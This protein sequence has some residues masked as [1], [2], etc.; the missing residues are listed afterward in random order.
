MNKERQEFLDSL[1]SKHGIGIVRIH[2]IQRDRIYDDVVKL[3]S[4]NNGV[5]TLEYP[6]HVQFHNE[7][8]VDVGGVTRDMF[9]AF[10]DEVYV[11]LFD[12]ST[13]LHPAIH[14][15]VDL[16]TFRVIGRVFS[17]AYLIAGM[18]PDRIAFPCLAA[19]FLGQSVSIP[20]IVL[21]ESFLFS[22]CTYDA[23]V[24]NKALKLGD[25]IYPQDI[26]EGLNTIFSNKGC[27]ELPCAKNLTRLISQA[28]YYTFLIKPAAALNMLN[29]GIPQQHIQFWE[30]VSVQKLKHIY[31]VLSVSHIKVLKLL[32]EPLMTTAAEE[33]VWLYLRQFIGNMSRDELRAFLRFTTGSFVICLPRI[34]VIFNKLQGIARR[35]IAHTCSGTLELS[36][37]YASLPEFVGEFRAV[38]TTSD[39]HTWTMDS[40]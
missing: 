3:Y 39:C 8:A 34:T 37:C 7:K 5:V 16:N 22:L 15:S 6:F 40:I 2:N 36:T 26:Q 33:E 4:E 1:N 24:V 19:I 18:F 23:L 13:S 20:D 21:H 12:G 10:F 14:P 38:L 28:A 17:H 30:G 29:S 35:P 11:H 27:R 31:D 32:K 9:S 25:S